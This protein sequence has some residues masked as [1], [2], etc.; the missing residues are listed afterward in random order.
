MV[1]LNK[2]LEGEV[3]SLEANFSIAP[4]FTTQHLPSTNSHLTKTSNNLVIRHQVNELAY[5][6]AISET[7]LEEAQNGLREDYFSRLRETFDVLWQMQ[8]LPTIFIKCAIHKEES[9]VGRPVET[10]LRHSHGCTN[11]VRQVAETIKFC[12]SMPKVCGYA[13]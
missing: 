7:T 10:S 9:K 5:K 8:S 11:L 3:Q 4:S 1:I 2:E 13:V 12:T 6:V